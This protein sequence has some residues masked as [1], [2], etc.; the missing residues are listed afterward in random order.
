MRRVLVLIFAVSFVAPSAQ[1]FGA[2]EPSTMH[3]NGSA[4]AE[5]P[6]SGGGS[7]S[8]SLTQDQANRIARAVGSSV[9]LLAGVGIG[10]AA[11]K[12]EEDLGRYAAIAETGLG[13][14]AVGVAVGVLLTSPKCR[15]CRVLAV[16]AGGIG[17][18]ALG[19]WAGAATTT[20]P[21]WSRPAAAGVGALGL[22]GG[23]FT[24]M[25]MLLLEDGRRT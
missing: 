23:A 18:G 2:E 6:S 14:A 4:S 24:V 13:G 19:T 10:L 9:G 12:R 20:S 17:G 22:L 8:R 15:W 7:E 11:F 5:S 16:S 3:P 25:V 1:A 21:G